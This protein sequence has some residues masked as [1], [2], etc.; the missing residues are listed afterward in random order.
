MLS[1]KQAMIPV[2]TMI[3]LILMSVLYW[4]A[5]IQ[6]ALFFEII[7]VISLS[8]IW[9]Y[10]WIEIE[11]MLFSSFKN[12][13]NVIMI[14]FLIG[15]MIGIWIAIGTVPT[16]IYYG[17]KTINPRYFLVLSFISTSIVSMAVGTAV[18][19]A[20]TI[21]LALISIAESLGL[22]MPLAAGAIISGSYVGDR[23]SPV[24][25][26]ANITAH[27]TGTDLMD[28][29]YHMFYT[30]LPAYLTAALIYLVIG[31]NSQSVINQSNNFSDL[32]SLLNEHFFISFWMLLPPIVIII[33]AL[34]RMPTIINLSLNIIFSIFLGV[35][36]V[37]KNWSELL[38]IM[39]GGFT[40]MTGIS[41]IDN[42]ISRGGLTS[43]LELISL[44]IFAVILGGILEQIGVLDSILKPFLKHI[45]EKL[46]LLSVTF[47]SSIISAVL[48]CNQFL[49]VFLPARMLIKYYDK[50][51]FERKDLARA[52]G[53]SGLVFSPLIPWNVNALMMTAVLGVKTLDYMYFAFFILLM[54]FSNLLVSYFEIKKKNKL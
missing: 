28:M 43:M 32:I 40:E 54:P 35:F 21:G 51:E 22:S 47:F 34:M 8:L 49:A 9:G 16:M 39:F 33:L 42:I 5:P 29:V 20:S 10:K 23:M 31:L 2:F 37:G 3:F 4:D 38:N 30:A 48:G 15:M 25:S 14:L 11:E 36:I 18:G 6:M 44:I 19:T 45:K 1:F 26:I 41:F 12:I 7:I 17:L 52:L 53:D 24:S 13:G 46:H 50:M 27:S